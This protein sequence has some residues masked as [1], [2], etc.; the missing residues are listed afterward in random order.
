MTF[1]RVREIPV[2]IL[3][4]LQVPRFRFQCIETNSI[5]YLNT[6]A[7]GNATG[8]LFFILVG[9]LNFQNAT[10]GH[11][12][13]GFVLMAWLCHAMPQVVQLAKKWQILTG[14]WLLF[15]PEWRIDVLWLSLACTVVSFCEFTVGEIDLQ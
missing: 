15:V 11:T 1:H 6:F 4:G 13:H 2:W 3:G 9:R 5:K 8:F 10:H 12:M 14:K 7:V